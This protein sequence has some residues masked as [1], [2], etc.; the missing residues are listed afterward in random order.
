[1][2]N[3]LT[4]SPPEGLAFTDFT[5]EFDAPVEAVFEVHR[6]PGLVRR[7]LGPHGYE[8]EIEVWDFT[9]NGHHHYVHRSPDGGEYA[10]HGVFHTVRDNELPSRPSSSRH[11]LTWSASTR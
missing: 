3:Q 11:C 1:M 7:W 5:R 9:T 10:F 8:M 4:N 6:D 2:I